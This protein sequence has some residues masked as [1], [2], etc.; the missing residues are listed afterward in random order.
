MVIDGFGCEA[1]AV[2]RAMAS[3][4][5]A[6]SPRRSAREGDE[7]AAREGPG[8]AR[9]N[10][11]AR[12]LVAKTG[13]DRGRFPEGEASSVSVTELHECHSAAAPAR[14]DLPHHL[15]HAADRQ[16]RAIPEYSPLTP[17]RSHG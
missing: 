11:A 16:A 15:R 4:P 13:L 1:P 5:P 9:V 10:A 2:V 14:I 6:Y 3:Q 7:S 12:V 17:E 8:R